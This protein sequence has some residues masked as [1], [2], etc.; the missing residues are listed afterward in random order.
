[1]TASASVVISVQMSM[2]LPFV[3]VW[4]GRAAGPAVGLAIGFVIGFV[5]AVANRVASFA[6]GS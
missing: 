1:M 6:F 4:G 2:E 5:A 3:Q